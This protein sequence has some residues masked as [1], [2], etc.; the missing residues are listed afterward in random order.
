MNNIE[1]STYLQT[2][3]RLGLIYRNWYLY[4]LLSRF[5]FGRVLDVGCGVGDLLAF[6][7][8]ATGV[9][10]NPF[11]VDFCL[12]RGLSARLMDVDKLPLSDSTCDTVVLDNVLEHIENPMPILSEIMRVLDVDGRLIVGVPG[13]K[14]YASDSDHKV[15]YDEALLQTMAKKSGFRI[16]KFIYTPLVKSKFLSKKINQYCIY[17]VWV[18]LDSSM[19]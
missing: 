11:N 18:P 16:L 14:G 1:Y 10:I 6:Q 13:I 19:P 2:R 8:G 15:F 17:S 9:D 4:P 5:F 12:Q 7:K 3:S